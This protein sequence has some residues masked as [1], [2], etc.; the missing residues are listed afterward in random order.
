MAQATIRLKLD[1]TFKDVVCSGENDDECLDSL[2]DN[3]SFHALLVDTCLDALI[4]EEGIYDE[5]DEPDRDL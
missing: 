3:K 5:P 4:I 1:I 2:V